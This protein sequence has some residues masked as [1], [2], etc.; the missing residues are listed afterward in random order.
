M[1]DDEDDENSLFKPE[2]HTPLTEY[3]YKCGQQAHPGGR[4]LRSSSEG[5]GG[6]GF[7]RSN[8]SQGPILS[9]SQAQQVNKRASRMFRF[10]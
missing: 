10:H 7:Y 1:L 6:G 2:G 4:C 3:C 8:L 5:S 9:Y